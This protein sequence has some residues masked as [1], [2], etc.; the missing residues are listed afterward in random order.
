MLC[1]FVWILGMVFDWILGMILS[2]M[3]RVGDWV[4]DSGKWCENEGLGGQ[5]S[6]ISQG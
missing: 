1:W 4:F 2:F 3:A 5:D 6:R